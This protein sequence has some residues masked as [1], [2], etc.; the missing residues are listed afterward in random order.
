MPPRGSGR[1]AAPRQLRGKRGV[2]VEFASAIESEVVEA[3]QD[4]VDVP[5]SQAPRKAAAKEGSKKK[6]KKAD[7]AA[8]S[9]QVASD[10]KCLLQWPGPKYT[11]QF[12]AVAD[13]ATV[14]RVGG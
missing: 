1:P 6:P 14:S 10:A 11:G 9:P 5:S 4:L 12:R 8:A 2:P 13:R 3:S 7:K